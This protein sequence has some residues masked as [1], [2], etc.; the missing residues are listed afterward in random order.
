MALPSLSGKLERDFITIY[1]MRGSKKKNKIAIKRVSLLVGI[2]LF[3]LGAV[4]LRVW[5]EMQVVK[6]GYKL[7]QLQRQYDG[8]LN[9][10]R[11]LLS[12]RNSL[13]SLERV[14]EIAN[15]KLGLVRPSKENL[16]FVVDPAFE[17]NSSWLA[18]KVDWN[19]W[20]QQICTWWEE[21]QS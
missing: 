15:E 9:Q 4:F 3:I 20:W 11:I 7:E 16:I 18:K 17:K 2:I 10:E 21:V 1:F 19:K 5:Q 6:I 12:K 8:L 14:E 13:M